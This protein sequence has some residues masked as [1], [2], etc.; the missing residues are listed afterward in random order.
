ML[1]TW[2]RYKYPH[3]ID[4]VIAGSA[5]IWNFEGEVYTGSFHNK[6]HI[7]A[8]ANVDAQSSTL[9]MNGLIA[10]DGPFSKGYPSSLSLIF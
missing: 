4:G 9:P 1:G 8:W 6:H 7:H 5:P 3:V 10:K 2:F